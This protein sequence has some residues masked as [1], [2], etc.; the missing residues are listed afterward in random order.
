MADCPGLVTIDGDED[1][2]VA[3]Q[4]ATWLVRAAGRLTPR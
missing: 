2:Q 4:A 3:S 1:E